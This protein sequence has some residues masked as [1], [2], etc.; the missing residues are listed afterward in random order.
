MAITSY[1][2]PCPGRCWCVLCIVC[3]HGNRRPRI[4]K[5]FAANAVS[6]GQ[7]ISPSITLAP[8]DLSVAPGDHLVN[9]T[10]PLILRGITSPVGMC[11]CVCVCVVLAQASGTEVIIFSSVVSF[12]VNTS[13]ILKLKV[14]TC[15]KLSYCL[16]LPQQPFFKHFV[17]IL[18]P[19]AYTVTNS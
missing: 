15:S 5:A 10:P 4:V 6:F 8:S 14:A 11:V 19:R 12:R 7:I 13:G 17:F 18:H 16:S 1:T 2:K 9:S 3:C